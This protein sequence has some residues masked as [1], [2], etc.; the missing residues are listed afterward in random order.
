MKMKNAP[1]LSEWEIFYLS[2]GGVGFLPKAPGTWGTL[3]TLPFLWGLGALNFPNFLAIPFII[4]ITAGT[5]YV[6]EVVQKRYE[7]HDPQWI[8]IDEVLGMFVTWFFM[9][10][11]PTWHLIPAFILFRFFDIVKIWPASWFD[12]ELKHG[13]GT[14][15]DD[16]ISGMYAGITYYLLFQIILPKF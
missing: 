1:R 12:K 10:G 15:L 2:F 13:A 14:I 3:A 9:T 6:T 5:C 11:A 7:L 8:V 4:F 16:I